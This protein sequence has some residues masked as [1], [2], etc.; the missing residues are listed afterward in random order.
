MHWDLASIE[1]HRRNGQRPELTTCNDRLAA[2]ALAFGI[3]VLA[4]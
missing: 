2:G 1:F 3:T 4:L